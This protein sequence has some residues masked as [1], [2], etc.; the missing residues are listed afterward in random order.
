MLHHLHSSSSY[1]ESLPILISYL[2]E[3][4]S[5]RSES[6]VKAQYQ[7]NVLFPISQRSRVFQWKRF[8]KAHRGKKKNSSHCINVS[9]NFTDISDQDASKLLI[10][11]VKYFGY[12][13]KISIIS[14]F[15]C[16]FKGQLSHNLSPSRYLYWYLWPWL[17]NRSHILVKIFK[18]S[19]LKEISSQWLSTHTQGLVSPHGR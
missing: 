15:T 5:K 19:S 9:F 18:L 12:S 13:I 14:W 3:R 11:A 8:F 4:K 16:G 6:S 7:T 17:T 10:V 2:Q 1:L